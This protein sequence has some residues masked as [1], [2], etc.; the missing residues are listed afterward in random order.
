MN[1]INTETEEKIK[2]LIA[3]AEEEL[4]ESFRVADEISEYN[5]A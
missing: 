4:G 2:A 1:E 3:S 5:Q